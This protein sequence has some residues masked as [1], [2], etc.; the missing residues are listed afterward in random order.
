MG[1]FV[2]TN[3]TSQPQKIPNISSSTKQNGNG[4]S[5]P[6]TCPL[7][8]EETVKEVLSE[9]TTIRRFHENHRNDSRFIK[10]HDDDFADEKKIHQNGTVFKEKSMGNTVGKYSGRISEPDSGLNRPG[11]GY[12]MRKDIGESSGRRSSSRVMC[13]DSWSAKTGL[14]GGQS[15]GRVEFGSGERTR[16]V[17]EGGKITWTPTSNELLENPL[18][19]LEC[20]I[21]L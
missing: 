7:P 9:T 12:G 3:N 14:V 19:S 18:V 16:K 1:C 11:P 10:R 8:E 15:P 17:D 6:P 13:T 21:F 2:S 20:F 5:P 4:K